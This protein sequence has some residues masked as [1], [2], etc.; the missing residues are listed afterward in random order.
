MHEYLS[1]FPGEAIQTFNDETVDQIDGYDN[2]LCDKGHDQD[3]KLKLNVLWFLVLF[4]KGE[5]TIDYK[6]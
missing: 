1:Y 6:T 5:G 2:I 3:I 4:E